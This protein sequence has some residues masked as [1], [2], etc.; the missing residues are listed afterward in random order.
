M[1][2]LGTKLFIQGDTLSADDVNGYFMSQVVMKFSTPT[3]RDLAF[4]DGIP[5]SIGGSGKPS[6]SAGMVCFVQY[7][8]DGTTPLNQVQYYNGATWQAADQFTLNDG[9]VTTVKIADGAITSDKIAAD[10]VIAADIAAGAVGTSELA[11]GSVTTVK[12]ADSNVTTAKIADSNV[13]TAKIADSNVTTAKIADGGVTTVKISDSNVTTAKIADSNVTTVKIA[14]SNVTTAKIADA[15]ITSA[16]IADNTIV[17]ADINSSAAIALSKLASGTNAQIIVASSGGVPTYVT[18]SGDATISNTGVVTLS[19]NSIA[20][21]SE[22]TGDYV[23]N[24]VAGT[25]VTITNNS[26]EGSTPT[27]A[28]G[29]SV[30]TSANPTFAG[31]TVDAVQIGITAA[32]EIDTT[33]GNLTIDSAG[34]TVTVDDNL[35]VTGNL[36]VSGTTTSINTETITLDDNIIILNNNESGAPSQNAGVE[37][38]RGTSTN[39]LIRWNES[40]DKWEI[41]NDGSTY[42]NIITTADTGTI[43][44]TMILDGTISNTDISSTAAIDRSKIADVS[45][46]TKTA[47]YTLTLNDKNKIIEMNVSSSNFVYVPTNASVAFPVGTQIQIV[48]YGSGKTKIEAVT[49]GT[50]SIRATP[51]VFLRAQYASATLIKRGTDEWYLL[52]DLS[53][54]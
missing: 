27:I 31:A 36:T 5:V 16:K 40:N 21:G 18:M 34:G 39:V 38:E 43:T 46:D 54:T 2:G 23:A 19:A 28:I 42:G 12:I 48:Q 11:D 22:T 37:I 50:T 1:P 52:G 45:L 49:S 7:E 6:L 53:L 20:L 24:L 9:Q 15:A 25:G 51:G 13:T 30:A 41:T 26:G 33:A 32:G 10:T 29:Q 44:S 35:T 3:T 14:D 47:N 17:N 4:G 8:S